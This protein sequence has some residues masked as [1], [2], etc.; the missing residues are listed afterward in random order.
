MMSRRGIDN[1]LSLF[2]ITNCMI[3]G[4]LFEDCQYLESHPCDAIDFITKYLNSDISEDMDKDVATCHVWGTE[5]IYDTLLYSIDVKRHDGK[6]FIND[7][8]LAW[9]GYLYRYWVWWLGDSSKNIIQVY[10]AEMVLSMFAGL[11]TLD[12]KESI[13]ML[14]E[15]ATKRIL[16]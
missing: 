13:R 9:A 15:A 7:R 10:P 12:P 16:N 8:S 5:Q 1:E 2:A 6:T 4:D 3:Q 14:K 11:H